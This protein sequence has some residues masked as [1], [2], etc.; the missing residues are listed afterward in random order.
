MLQEYSNFIA[1]QWVKSESGKT[2]Q[3]VNPA[4]TS[5]STGTFQ[6]S[7]KEDAKR[8]ISSAREAFQKWKN[9]PAPQRGKILHEAA[10]ILESQFEE[11]SRILTTEEGKTLSESKGEVQRAID[12]FRFY[13]GQGSRLSGKTVQS[14]SK[15]TLLYSI[16][17]P[18]G[19]VALLT[20]WNFPIAIPAWKMAPA[21]VCGNT[22]VFKPASLTPIIAQR[23]VSA[24][25]KAGLP[26]GVL[27]YITGPGSTVGEELATNSEVDAISFTGSYDVGYGIQRGRA[28]SKK[29][30][31]IQLEM[32][33]KNPTIILPDA[34]LDDA[35]VIVAR[36][37]FGLTGQACTATS[38]VIVHESV[39]QIFLQKLI[40]QA[41]STKVSDGLKPETQMGP[42]V[43]KAELEKDL[44]YV[45]IGKKEGA[46]L[47][48][49]GAKSSVAE[50]Q[51][52]HFIDPTVF[53][54]VSPD[55]RIAKEE[56][57]GPVIS[58]LSAKNLEEAI[59]LANNSEYGLTA[60]LCTSN[61][62][63][64]LEFAER[65]DAGVVKINKMTTGL[66]LH[67]PFG[68]FKKSSANTFK[69]QGEEAVD[70]YTRIKTVYVGY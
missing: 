35:A 25:E 62:S 24:L 19:V 1:G 20:P 60:G 55:M 57:F 41:R 50:N 13:A 38:R 56:I 42:A 7:S 37:S 10:N 18:L 4:D 31:R 12:I 27:N 15:R 69:E 3:N 51:R 59:D 64:A 48:V 17:E 52:G 66:E 23:L 49:G 8:A 61:L 45:E 29:M 68:G 6:L 30:A 11:L 39:K 46:R 67:V 44:N 53:D 70:F 34:K 32:G 63:S 2:F 58:V 36:S 14:A 54:N 5:K 40:E 28:S 65:V 21:L 9:T 43:S 26:A 22:V 33:G 16:R 47:L